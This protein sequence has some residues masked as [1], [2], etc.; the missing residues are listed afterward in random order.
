MIYFFIFLFGICF[1]SFCNV[2]IHR[3]PKSLSIVS[4]RSKC[5][6][7]EAQLFWWHN[8]PLISFVL[9]RAKCHFCKEPISSLYFLVELFIGVL[10]VYLFLLYGLSFSFV[11][12]SVLFALLLSL[13]IIDIRYQAVPDSINISALSLA[14]VF[15]VIN[16]KD[17]FYLT[18][19]SDVLILVGVFY[20]LRFY[21][22][23]FLGQEAMGEGDILIGG[24]MGGLLGVELALFAI[25][26][27]A[28]LAL[29]FSMYARKKGQFALPFIPFLVSAMSLVFFNQ[30]FSQEVVHYA[31]R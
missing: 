9:L 30:E 3:T 31:T 1:G 16:S 26:V 6:H 11:L 13:C 23:F 27:S 8:I 25:F 17:F 12:L 24:V 21:V 19:L 20:V 7:C 10:F 28:F 4:P 22:S 14:A 29:P 5:P 2:L 15:A 18:G